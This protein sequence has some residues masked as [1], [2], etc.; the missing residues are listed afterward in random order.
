MHIHWHSIVYV[1]IYIY[2]YICVIISSYIL[3]F[4][5][6]TWGWYDSWLDIPH[7][8]WSLR[9]YLL[10]PISGCLRPGI[11][12]TTSISA[13]ISYISGAMFWHS[14]I[15]S[16]KTPGKKSLHLLK[17]PKDPRTKHQLFWHR[18]LKTWSI[19]ETSASSVG[20]WTSFRLQLTYQ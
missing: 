12:I 9:N 3:I 7:C 10:V 17:I 8:Y 6:N 16:K 19:P 14:H 5:S 15:I 1:Y 13:Y 2:I 18:H 20:L 4:H 11:P